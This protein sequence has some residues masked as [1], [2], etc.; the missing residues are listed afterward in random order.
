VQHLP[1]AKP[2]RKELLAFKPS[3]KGSD[4]GGG[5]AK[6]SKKKQDEQPQ[7]DVFDIKTEKRKGNKFWKELEGATAAITASIK[8]TS[9]SA[10]TTATAVPAP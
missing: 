10:G 2:P 4:F 1:P 9:K 6:K 8:Q 7:A 3:R 5:S